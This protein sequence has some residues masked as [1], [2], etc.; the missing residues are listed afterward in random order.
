MINYM[1]QDYEANGATTFISPH[2]NYATDGYCPDWCK[3]RVGYTE[4][5]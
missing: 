1:K 2:Y 4:E 3:V 5:Q